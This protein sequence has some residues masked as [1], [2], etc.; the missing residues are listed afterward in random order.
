MWRIVVTAGETC[1][2]SLTETTYKRDQGR[3][4]RRNA[5]EEREGE[6]EGFLEAQWSVDVS[7]SS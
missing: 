7:P 2:P 6:G 4:R 3:W 5:G 1:L